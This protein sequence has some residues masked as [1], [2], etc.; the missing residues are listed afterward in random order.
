MKQ[1][2]IDIEKGDYESSVND[3]KEALKLRE[4]VFPPHSREVADAL[5]FVGISFYYNAETNALFSRDDESLEKVAEEQAH[6]AIPYLE[7][8]KAV[9]EWLAVTKAMEEGLIAKKGATRL[10]C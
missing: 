8:A 4:A 2:E 1:G 9:M 3:H 5:F 6:S 10:V 7:R